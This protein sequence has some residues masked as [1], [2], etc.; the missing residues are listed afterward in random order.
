MILLMPRYILTD[1]LEKQ[2]AEDIEQILKKC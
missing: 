1:S 2:E